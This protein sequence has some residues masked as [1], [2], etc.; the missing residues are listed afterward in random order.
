MGIKA[1]AGF[2]CHE[3]SGEDYIP[4]WGGMKNHAILSI[5]LML[6]VK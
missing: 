6:S 2:T 5:Y 4:L 1:I 3:K